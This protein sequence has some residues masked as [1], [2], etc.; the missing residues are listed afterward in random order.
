MTAFRWGSGTDVGHVRS[1][2]QDNLVVAA[3]FFAVAD[4]MGGHRGGEVASLIAV[5]A[6]VESLGETRRVDDYVTAVRAANEA[7]L[8]RASEDPDL[9]GMGTTLCTLG[10]VDVDGVE[11]LA[12]TNV[13]DSR[14]YRYVDDHLAQVTL[15]HSL[16]EDLLRQG[17]LSPEEARD[18]PQR[19]VL[20]RAL[21]VS[22]EVEVDTFLLPVIHGDR[23]MLCSDGLFNEVSEPD[24]AAT[25]GTVDDP[26]VAAQDLIDAAN[27]AG[28]RDNI[29]VVIVDV[30]M[31]GSGDAV[32]TAGEPTEEH[33]TVAADLAAPGSPAT[34]QAADDSDPDAGEDTPKRPWWRRMF[35]R[36]GA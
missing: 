20:T 35:G 7:I 3:G 6:L 17:R 4:G 13:G 1:V 36:G 10:L 34:V 5:E 9:Y 27:R 18:H 25:L 8:Q 2:N 31:S 16:V 30:D 24:I 32:V 33:Q 15:D 19:N 12:V 26:E 22:H 29:T 14:V 21:G 28:S 11:Q 23:F